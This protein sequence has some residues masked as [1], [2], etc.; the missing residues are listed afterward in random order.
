MG[1]MVPI[2]NCSFEIYPV[3]IGTRF[4]SLSA[5]IDVTISEVKSRLNPSEPPIFFSNEELGNE[6]DGDI[7][8][9]EDYEECRVK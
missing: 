7:N 9:T 5:H 8:P 3:F 4:Y 1:F 2:F 6:D